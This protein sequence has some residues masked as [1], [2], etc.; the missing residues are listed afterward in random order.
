[1]TAAVTLP[2]R[3]FA[4][5]W[6][7]LERWVIPSS[8][9][10]RETLSPG[11]KR[12]RIAEIVRN[13]GGH[14]LVE[15]EKEYK[16]AGV[17][18][19][20]EGV[21]H[22]ETVRGNTQ[23]AKFLT[24]LVPGALI[25]NRLFAWKASFAVVPPELADCF[26][27]SEFPQFILDT[28]LILPDY[29]YLFCVRDST[30]RAVNA[31]ST[32]S[33]AVSRNRFKEEEFLNFEISL[34]PITEQKLIVARWRAAKK[35]IA[36]AKERG[37]K[38]E[39]EICGFVFERLGL[40]LHESRSEL[41]KAIALWW[42]DLFVWGAGSN[43][44][45]GSNAVLLRSRFHPNIPLGKVAQINP[46]T[47]I[48]VAKNDNITFVPMEAVSEIE[49][50]I[51]SPK[52]VAYTEVSKGYT[53]FQENDVI[54]AK[55]TPCMQNGKSAVARNLHGGFGVGSTEFHVIRPRDIKSILPEFIW[56]L[57]RIKSLR[58]LAK[59][60]FVGSAG[61]Q[62]VPAIFLEEL[63][64]PHPPLKVQKQIV[65]RVMVK[66]A[67]IARERETAERIEKEITA[68]NEALILGTNKLKE[69]SNEV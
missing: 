14:V 59:K 65:E 34:P 9:L 8:L 31:A 43:R 35:Q 1:M 19:Y 11:W 10:L 25:Y 47:K 30:I 69:A 17:K 27:S 2:R 55:I 7:D 26:V 53:R 61:Q 56:V 32:G 46:S 60:Y 57:L 23:S 5:W 3:A 66:R 6:K 58:E 42:K 4:V 37:A 51:V 20:G 63:I 29:L 18:W 24:P 67:E 62:R 15:P 41:P 45:P 22:R 13:L 16:M 44:L 54:W 64:I 68:E 36:A 52:L 49:G 28:N 50:K 12:V 48:P 33:S 21:F 40:K 39:T 38:L